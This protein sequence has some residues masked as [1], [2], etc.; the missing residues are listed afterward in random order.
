[1]QRTC[2]FFLFCGIDVRYQTESSYDIR[3][4]YYETFFSMIKETTGDRVFD[5]RC[6]VRGF[7]Y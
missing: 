1:M 3:T 6:G 7:T 2:I 5:P 4:S